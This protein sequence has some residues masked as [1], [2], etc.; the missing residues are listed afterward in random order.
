MDERPAEK[1][2]KSS[3][4]IRQMVW[5]DV[6]KETLMYKVLHDKLPLMA[7]KQ[8][9][10]DA[11]NA[12]NDKLFEDPV[13]LP[14]KEGSYEKNNSRKIRDKYESLMAEAK[15]EME[16]GNLSKY[17]G[18]LGKMFEHAKKM[19][20]EIDDIEEAAKCEKELK[21]TLDETSEAVL[22][23]VNK[24][25]K[26][27]YGARKSLDG[28]IAVHGGGPSTKTPPFGSAPA[29]PTVGWKEKII[30]GFFATQAGLAAQA[31]AQAGLAPAGTNAGAMVVPHE[32][33]VE[34]KML[35]WVEEK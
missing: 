9:V 2:R 11:W 6:M 31:A 4:R 3:G 18:D 23:A 34:E 21:R 16:S 24:K 35:A 17:D 19:A 25:P 5:S 29:P 12:F 15:R 14:F 20:E 8:G 30:T 28:S 22:S 33:R 10:A 1:G 7:G 32:E 26:E 13:F 27:G